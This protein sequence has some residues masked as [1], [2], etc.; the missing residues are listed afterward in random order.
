MRPMSQAT[1]QPTEYRKPSYPWTAMPPE[2]PRNDAADR[3]SPDSAIPFC[4][5]V[6]LLPA[7]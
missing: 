4:G 7:A 1:T 3:K 5:P 2:M 6:K